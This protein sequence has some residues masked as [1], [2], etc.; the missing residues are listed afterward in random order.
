MKVS[1]SPWLRCGITMAV[2]R[3]QTARGHVRAVKVAT[4][5]RICMGDRGA[6]CARPP[7]PFEPKALA[8]PLDHGC[9]LHQYH[10]PEATRP[11]PLEPNPQH[12]IDG[13]QAQTAAPLTIQ[14]GYLMTQRDELQL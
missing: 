5:S 9:R 8:V 14:H 2:V 3:D 1:G 7:A 6:P 4:V 12:P 13:V 10:G 11:H